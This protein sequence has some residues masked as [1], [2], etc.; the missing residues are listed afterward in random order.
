MFCI[1]ITWKTPSQVHNFFTFL[2]IFCMERMSQKCKKG[3]QNRNSV[4]L[5]AR[6]HRFAMLKIWILCFSWERQHWEVLV[7]P[8]E[9]LGRTVTCIGF[10]LLITLTPQLVALL[11]GHR[12]SQPGV[13]TVPWYTADQMHFI[14]FIFLFGFLTSEYLEREALS[15]KWRSTK[16]I[17]STNLVGGLKSNT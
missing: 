13:L 8:W 5:A 4:L 9:A 1:F 12:H 7:I 2:K 11:C 16:S 6:K 10:S 17:Q 14:F 3:V 15:T